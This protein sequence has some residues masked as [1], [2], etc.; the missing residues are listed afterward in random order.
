MIMANTLATPSK[1]VSSKAFTSVSVRFSSRKGCT[2]TNAFCK[3]HEIPLLLRK[4]SL[5]DGFHSVSFVYMAR[6]RDAYFFMFAYLNR[7]VSYTKKQL[8]VFGFL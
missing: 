1:S 7:T 6:Y 3:I 4:E 5:L 2:D 8:L